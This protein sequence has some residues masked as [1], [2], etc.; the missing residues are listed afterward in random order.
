V[1]KARLAALS[2]MRPLSGQRGDAAS[3]W[4]TERGTPRWRADGTRPR[5]RRWRGR[6]TASEDHARFLSAIRWHTTGHEGMTKLEKIVYLA[7]FIEPNRPITRGLRNSARGPSG[8]RTA[9]FGLPRRI[10]CATC[11]PG[12]LSGR[13]TMKMLKAKN[14]RRRLYEAAQGHSP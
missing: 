9:R 2:T 14:R 10:P 8:T 7:D 4:A 13:N 12:A 6:S 1:E 3:W 5:A 11:A